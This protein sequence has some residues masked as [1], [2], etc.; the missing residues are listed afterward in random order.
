MR[1]AP[2]LLPLLLAAAAAC[3]R[4]PGREAFPPGAGAAV[5]ARVRIAYLHHS[6]GEAVWNGGVPG[7]LRA[8]NAAHG[9][10]YRID[11]L[12][13]PA[14]TAGLPPLVRRLAAT[15]PWANYPYDYWNLWVRHAGTRRDRGERNLDDLARS[16]DVIV[17]KHCFPVSRVQPGA[18][19]PSVS[20]PERTLA[21]YR[22]QYDAL[23]ARLRQFP[24]R[25]FIVWTAP[26]LPEPATSPAEAERARE[27]ALWVRDVWDEP[28]DNVIVWDF[29]ALETA[30]GLY[31]APE[32]AA[33]A[34]DAHP[35]PAFARE[36]APLLGRRIVDVIEGRGDSAP[37]TGRAG[38]TRGTPE[39]GRRAAR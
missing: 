7:F 5:S 16:H 34:R 13:Y 10:D 31:L 19:P 38:E 17:F 30:D 35:A 21:N 18:G 9:T 4:A 3:G 27:F 24:D 15:Y 12:T 20:S 29:R 26:A 32:R 22:L 6:T 11:R 28:G 23:K 37:L 36:V 25:R 14:T 33:G 1:I 2:T 39:G 8:W